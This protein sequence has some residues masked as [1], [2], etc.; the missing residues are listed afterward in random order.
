MKIS[1]K[2]LVIVALTVTEISLTLWSIVEISKGATFH[3]LNTRHLKYNAIF[4]EQVDELSIGHA[5]DA[6]MLKD[7]IQQIKQQ[8]IDCLDQVNFLNRFIMR[9]IG[10]I[11]A[12]EICRKDIVDSNAALA[13]VDRFEN[14]TIDGD[15]LV[16]ELKKF[17]HIFN[18]NSSMFEGPTNDTVSFVLRTMIPM[19]VFISLFNII[20]IGYMSRSISGSIRSLITLVSKQGNELDKVIE[21]NVTGELKELL[22]VTKE[23]LTHEIMMSEVNKLLE[24]VVKTRTESLE[25]A[26]SELEQFAYR[27]SHDLKAPLTS[28]KGL[29]RFIIEDI[30]SGQLE[31]AI[32]DAEKIAQQMEKL[33]DLVIGIL[34]LTQASSTGGE[35][36]PIDLQNITESAKEF[37]KVALNT[38]NIKFFAQVSFESPMLSEEVRI[39]QIIDNLVSNA[40]KY[41]D[42]NKPECI[43]KVHAYETEL[44]HVVEVEDNGLGIP[45]SRQGEMFE[46]FKR[47]HPN[48]SVGS[49]LGMSIVKKHMDSLKASIDAKSSKNGTRF[50]LTFPKREIV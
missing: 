24:G 6:T 42:E 9:Q 22:D 27:T 45:E 26:N 13:L 7:S 25:K 29:A 33:E 2:L 14:G 18:E 40:I 20:F 8:P 23:R 19:V 36:N 28:T 5:V 50:T 4:S 1:T 37:H 16:L 32:D 11:H 49:G 31:N 46:M 47:F 10:T 43:V 48:V 17:V 38:K 44:A 21:Q 12:L 15:M 41:S 35:M 39:K 34:S 30:K 3:Q